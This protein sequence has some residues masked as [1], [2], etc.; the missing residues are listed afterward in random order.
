MQTN[1]ARIK[2]AGSQTGPG[3]LHSKYFRKVKQM[4]LS[5]EQ[6]LAKKTTVLNATVICRHFDFIPENSSQLFILALSCQLHAHINSLI[7]HL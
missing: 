5:G 3:K 2:F 6:V 4:R 1:F 7:S